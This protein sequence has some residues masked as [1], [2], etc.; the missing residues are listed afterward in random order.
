MLV[1]HAISYLLTGRSQVD[2][3]HAY[4]VPAFEYSVT[5]LVAFCIVTLLRALSRP[6]PLGAPVYSFAQT[7]AR[8]SIVQIALFA[9]GERLEGF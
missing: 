7:W 3:H 2:A 1:G 8:L 6:A 4:T 5:L 9:I